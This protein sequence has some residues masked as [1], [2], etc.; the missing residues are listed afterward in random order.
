MNILFTEVEPWEERYLVKILGSRGFNLRF[1]TEP[2]LPTRIPVD[3]HEIEALGI[4]V[5]S[6]ITEEVI[7]KFP[8]LKVIMTLSTG[9]DH[10]DIDKCKSRGIAVY[11]VPNYG[12]HTVAEYALMLTLILLRKTKRLIK[13]I[14]AGIFT[15][16]GLRGSDAWRKTVG[17]VGTGRIGSWYARFCHALE[18]KVFAYDLYPRED[19]VKM[20][21]K[22]VSYETLL[23]EADIISYHVPHTPETHHMF[24]KKH[25]DLL[26]KRVYLV[27]TSRG[28]VINLDAVV[29]G[30]RRGLIAGVALDTFEAEPVLLEDAFL[31]RD[32]LAALDLMKA[33]ETYYLLRHE[34]VVLSPHNAYNTWEALTRILDITV[35][36]LYS[37]LENRKSEFRI[38]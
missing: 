13:Q 4:F 29:E 26:T 23:K 22:Y 37:F 2:V 15:R 25:L 10:I 1:E 11:Y 8:K 36:N 28:S 21:V 3:S 34:D 6:K 38:V 31:K 14:D 33:L 7:E 16:E 9:Y 17:V 20:G 19:L 30:L 32:D 27:N 12:D 35:E 24:D 5:G 18:M